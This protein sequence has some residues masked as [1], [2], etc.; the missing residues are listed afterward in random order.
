MK[1]GIIGAGL[2]GHGLALTAIRGSEI[3]S[4]SLGRKIV[5]VKYS[6]YVA[7][8]GMIAIVGSPFP[9]SC[10]VNFKD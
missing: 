3:A 10:R 6:V 1:V 2:M 8:T 9:T 5:R 7:V 4:S